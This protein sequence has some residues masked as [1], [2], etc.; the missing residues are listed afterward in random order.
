[1]LANP[2]LKGRW[3]IASKE[4]AQEF[5]DWWLRES[6]IYPVTVTVEQ[7]RNRSRE[8]NDLLWSWARLVSHVTGEDVDE[9]VGRWK[10]EFLLPEIRAS[11]EWV[12]QLAHSTCDQYADYSYRCKAANSIIRSSKLPVK[13]FSEFLDRIQREEVR[14]SGLQLPSPED[15]F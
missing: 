15:H 8:Q 2:S 11:D 12:D 6:D 4:R 14:K 7:G 5:F 9:V 10:L 3:Y 1:M 13:M